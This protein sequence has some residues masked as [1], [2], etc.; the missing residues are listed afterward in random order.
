MPPQAPQLVNSTATSLATHLSFQPNFSLL[1]HLS[2][3]LAIRLASQHASV[4]ILSHLFLFLAIQISHPSHSIDTHLSSWPPISPFE[5]YLFLATHLSDQP[6]S[7]VFNLPTLCLATRL[8][9]QPPISLLSHLSPLSH[10][11]L[12]FAYRLSPISLLSNS[13]P[14]LSEPP[15]SLLSRPSLFLA[16]HL[17]LLS[18]PLVSLLSHPPLNL[19]KPPI[20]L[21]RNTH[22][23]TREGWPMLTV[24]TEANGDSWSTCER[25]PSLDGGW[26][27]VLVVQIQQILVLPWMLQS[28]Q[29][30]IL[31][32]SQPTFFHFISPHRP[33]TWAGSRA[34]SPVSLSLSTHLLSHPSLL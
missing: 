1:S 20:S 33:A 17:P 9:S 21:P 34:G 22:K 27:V 4:S 14:S 10:P 23:E 2:L 5:P 13:N 16:N 6:P 32:S 25:V 7:S 28:A 3:F 15:V 30:K 18:K 11:S 24:E 12:F 8:T 29:Y 31:F 19:A 26:F